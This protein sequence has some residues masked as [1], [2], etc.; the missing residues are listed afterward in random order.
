MSKSQIST[1]YLIIL[2]VTLAAII[3]AGYFF[4]SYSR[5]QNDDSVRSQVAQIGEQI[6]IDAETVYGLA[7]GSLITRDLKYPPNILSIKILGRSELVIAYD[8]GSGPTEAVYFSKLNIT[9]AY[10]LAYAP[11]VPET[12]QDSSL[13]NEDLT[14]GKHSLKF[15]SRGSYVLITSS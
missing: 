11:G 4:Y 5:T 1:E 3:P 13:Y 10:T 8:L 14:G 6:L 9:G 15:E 7:E 12:L 2:G